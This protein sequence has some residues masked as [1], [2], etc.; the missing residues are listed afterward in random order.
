MYL[1]LYNDDKDNIIFVFNTCSA[2]LL[3]RY[4]KLYI[5]IYIII[6]RLIHL[7]IN[8]KSEEPRVETKGNTNHHDGDFRQRTCYL[9]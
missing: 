8:N 7:I 4:K 6:V 9:Q 2:K 5:Y 3:R 1:Y